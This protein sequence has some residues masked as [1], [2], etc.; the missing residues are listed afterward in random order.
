MTDSLPP[1]QWP[2]RDSSQSGPVVPPPGAPPAGPPPGGFTP[3]T[4]LPP[5]A[6]D[7]SGPAPSGPAPSSRRPP[8]RGP[9]IAIIGGVLAL[10]LLVV[11]VGAN[12]LGGG[13]EPAPGA[14]G[15]T[16]A[17]PL[18]PGAEPFDPL[19]PLDPG[20][21]GVDPLDPGQGGAP[22][23][24]G[25]GGDP[26]AYDP[27]LPNPIPDPTAAQMEQ[28]REL[29]ALVDD[30]ELA[31]I[32]WQ[33]RAW[34][35]DDTDLQVQAEVSA[36]ALR[37]IQARMEGL[38]L[39]GPPAAPIRAAYLPHLQAWIDYISGVGEDPST[40][41]SEFEDI[42]ATAQDFVAGIPPEVGDMSTLP[43][44]IAAL[45]REIVERGFTGVGGADTDPVF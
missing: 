32:D 10:V 14:G 3:P 34:G 7:D 5:P 24:G 12:L 40:L 27:N 9:L 19:D 15:A 18:D 2:G 42:N 25:G 45:I 11:V 1:P 43:G 21:P 4:S 35:L 16:A 26:L 6:W 31:M 38:D 39:S 41:G 30:A 33:N 36:Q 23:L 22:G 44:D 28:L 17:D 20:G 8:V 13:D 37:D 29:M